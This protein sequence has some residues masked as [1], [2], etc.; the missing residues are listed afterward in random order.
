MTFD[1]IAILGQL[2]ELEQQIAA[3]PQYRDS[4]QR[5]FGG[6]DGADILCNLMHGER[7][8]RAMATATVN[9]KHQILT[10]DGLGDTLESLAGL[11]LRAVRMVLLAELDALQN[12]VRGAAVRGRS[13]RLFDGRFESFDELTSFIRAEL[14][15]VTRMWSSDHDRPWTDRLAFR[16]ALGTATQAMR[17][18]TEV[19]ELS[20]FLRDGS[21]RSD[22][23]ELLRICRRMSAALSIRIAVEPDQPLLI[24]THRHDEL[25]SEEHL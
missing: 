23:P 12:L 10:A 2:Q 3:A 6:G 16:A 22:W 15:R 1:P 24:H 11:M 8:V 25:T 7:H 21:V 4:L 5:A 18:L 9:I 19:P 14:D 13:T 20:R 17:H